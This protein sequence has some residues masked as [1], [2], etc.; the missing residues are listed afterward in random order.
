MSTCRY[1]IY[2]LCSFI[3]QSLDYLKINNLFS[4]ELIL[5]LK[6]INFFNDIIFEFKTQVFFAE[7]LKIKQGRMFAFI[8][9]LGHTSSN[10]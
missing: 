1:T 9:Y 7:V 10:T 8:D 2:I 5:K 6:K 4:K 3:S